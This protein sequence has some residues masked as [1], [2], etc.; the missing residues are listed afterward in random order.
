MSLT[1][2]N[3]VLI[4]LAVISTMFIILGL[5]MYLLT[6]LPRHWISDSSVGLRWGVKYGGE[7]S[8]EAHNL[9][10]VPTHFYGLC[11]HEVHSYYKESR[12]KHAH[13]SI[14]YIYIYIYLS[15]YHLSIYLSIYLSS[16]YLSTHT[17]ISLPCRSL[18]ILRKNNY[19][20]DITLPKKITW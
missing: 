7:L 2:R 19:I 18:Y 20:L 1:I 3:I 5:D 6:F 4:T 11:W 13:R 9:V 12:K 8:N 14:I 17:Y 15:I 10:C 16:I